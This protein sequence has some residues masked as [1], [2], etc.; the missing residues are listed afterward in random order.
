MEVMKGTAVSVIVVHLSSKTKYTFEA[1]FI[2]KFES[3]ILQSLAELEHFGAAIFSVFAPF[4]A[5]M[6]PETALMAVM[7]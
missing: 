5:V 6:V 3:P 4:I 2:L 1:Q 7:R